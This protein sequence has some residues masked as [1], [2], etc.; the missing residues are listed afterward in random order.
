MAKPLL[1]EF[2]IHHD[3]E[4]RVLIEYLIVK[5]NSLFQCSTANILKLSLKDAP[6]VDN[7]AIKRR[8]GPLVKIIKQHC[9]Q[10]YQIRDFNAQRT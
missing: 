8:Y 1:T 2:A 6:R 7:K 5:K 10:C 4:S 3:L 9:Y